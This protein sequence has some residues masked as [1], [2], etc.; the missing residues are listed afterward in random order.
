MLKT[1]SNGVRTTRVVAVTVSHRII[2]IEQALVVAK[3]QIISCVPSYA[4]AS[5]KKKNRAGRAAHDEAAPG[6]I[7]GAA[8]RPYIFTCR[9]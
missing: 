6:A 1:I 4:G 8:P 5:V 7:R 2:L 3:V 9:I